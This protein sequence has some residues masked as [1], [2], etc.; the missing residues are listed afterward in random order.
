MSE[1]VH[2]GTV[3]VGAGPAGLAVGACL[4]RLDMPFMILKQGDRVGAKLNSLP[5]TLL[6]LPLLCC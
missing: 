6:P 3:I 2:T 5:L 4:R 1:I